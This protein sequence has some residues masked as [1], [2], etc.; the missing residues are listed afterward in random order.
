MA[1]VNFAIRNLQREQATRMLDQINEIN[2][3]ILERKENL[4][5]TIA[6]IEDE[7]TLMTRRVRRQ[8]RIRER[9]ELERQFEESYFDTHQS[10]LEQQRVPDT[11]LPPQMEEEE[12]E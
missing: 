8:E 1:N 2:N 12:E 6:Q 3:A 4:E 9:E 5:H 10:E 7:I 11:T